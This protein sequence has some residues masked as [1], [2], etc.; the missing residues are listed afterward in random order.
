MAV[1]EITESL[2]QYLSFVSRQYRHAVINAVCDA[3]EMFPD[4]EYTIDRDLEKCYLHR[5][6]IVMWVIELTSADNALEVK[7]RL[8]YAEENVL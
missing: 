2:R 1:T 8:P 6:S 5:G 3:Q 4:A 7:S